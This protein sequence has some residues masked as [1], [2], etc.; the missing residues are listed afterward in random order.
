MLWCGEQE[1]NHWRMGL[2]LVHGHRCPNVGLLIYLT[3]NDLIIL[4]PFSIS[5]EVM[6]LNPLCENVETSEGV[7]IT[8]T[9]VAQCKIIVEPELLGRACE[10]FLG[11]PVEHIAEV[12]RQT[13]E[14]HLRAILGRVLSCDFSGAHLFDFRNTECG[15]HLPRQRSV[16]SVG[17]RGCSSRCWPHGHWNP[18]FHHQGCLR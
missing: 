8:V 17:A 2:G 13:L 14:G 3:T 10:Q 18:Q 15:S 16:C 6:T 1:D 9:G 5:L 4:L 11:K 12:V 7:P